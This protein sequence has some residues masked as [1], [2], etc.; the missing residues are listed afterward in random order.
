MNA[1]WWWPRRDY[2]FRTPSYGKLVQCWK[3]WTVMYSSERRQ[4]SGAPLLSRISASYRW[5]QGEKGDSVAVGVDKSLFRLRWPEGAC[6]RVL[7]PSTSRVRF[8]SISGDAAV[9]T[10]NKTSRAYPRPCGVSG[11]IGKL[12]EVVLL[13]WSSCTRGVRRRLVGS[14]GRWVHWAFV[15]WIE[16]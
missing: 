11:V 4:T 3:L 8:P 6:C 14:K 7:G 10:W 5:E 2:V 12:V 1:S 16:R 13:A 9:L 15:W